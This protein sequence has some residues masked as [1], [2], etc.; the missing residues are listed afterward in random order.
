MGGGGGGCFLN[1]RGGG[2]L[3]AHLLFLPWCFTST[4]T[5]GLIR[6]GRMMELRALINSPVSEGTGR[7]EWGL[8][9]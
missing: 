5:M 6:D 3:F 8:V 4:E 1:G 7:P 9:L 2:G